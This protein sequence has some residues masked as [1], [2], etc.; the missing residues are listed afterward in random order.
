MRLYQLK[1]YWMRFWMI[2][3]SRSRFGR[4]ATW[5]ATIVAPPFFRRNRLAEYNKKGYISPKATIDHSD[6]RLGKNIFI[7]DRVDIFRD[8][9]GGSVTLDDNVRLHWDMTI[10]TG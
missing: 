6:L 5:M 2:F 1:D 7:G 3:A 9:E 8:S 10:Q 4:L